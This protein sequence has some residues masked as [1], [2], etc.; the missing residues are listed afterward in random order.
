M[1]PEV[2]KPPLAPKPRLPDRPSAVAVQKVIPSQISKSGRGLYPSSISKGPKPPIAPKPNL[3]NNVPVSEVKLA[4][5]KNNLNW[6]SNGKLLVADQLVVL[7]VDDLSISDTLDQSESAANSPEIEFAPA[8]EGDE[9]N[10]LRDCETAKCRKNGTAMLDDSDQRVIAQ[11]D[12]G[13]VQLEDS[14]LSHLD[15]YGLC[16][17]ADGLDWQC[18]ASQAIV[19]VVDCDETDDGIRL[20]DVA[21][22]ECLLQ[23]APSSTLHAARNSNDEI[24]SEENVSFIQEKEGFHGKDLLEAAERYTSNT[25]NQQCEEPTK[26]LVVTT[27]EKADGIMDE[28]QLSRVLT[29][30][31]PCGL[32]DQADKLL[33]ETR[34]QPAPT[35]EAPDKPDLE[36]NEPVSASDEPGAGAG[37]PGSAA[38]E[39]GVE[40]DEPESTA[41]VLGA[42]AEES[43][44]ALDEPG[45]GADEP[46]AGADEPRDEDVEP[47][48]GADEPGAGADE[49]RDEDVEP[50]TGANEP[51]AGAD[52]PRDE[53]V[54]PRDEDVEPGA[55]ADEPGAGAD[56]PGTG[57]DEPGAGADE[58]G[59]GADEPRDEDVEP[60]TGADEPGAGADDPRDE[61]IEPGSGAD[62]PG[63]GAD[64]PGAEED[65]PGAGADEPG[66]G[67]EEPRD[68]DVEPGAGADVPGAGADGPGAE[69]DE[70]GAGADEPGAGA[71]E[72]R[73]EDVEPGTGADE[74]GTGAD[75]P[76]DEDDEPGTGADE[77]GTGADEPRDEDVKPGAGADGPGTGADEPRDEDV[78]PGAGAD[79]PGAGADEPGAG[80]DEPGDED[81]E[82]GDEDVEPGAGADGPGAR[83]DGPGARADGPGA[84]ADGPGA[85][86]DEPG[87]GADEPSASAD[88]PEPVA[89]ADEPGAGAD[90]PGAGADEPGAG[91]GA[92][93]PEAKVDKPRAGADELVEA[94]LTGSSKILMFEGDWGCSEQEMCAMALDTGVCEEKEQFDQS[95]EALELADF[96][97]T[98]EKDKFV[99]RE[100]CTGICAENIAVEDCPASSNCAVGIAA[101]AEYGSLLEKEAK[102]DGL[103]SVY[104]ASDD[105][106]RVNELIGKVEADKS[107]SADWRNTRTRTQ[108]LGAQVPET[109]P[110]EAAPGSLLQKPDRAA[111][112]DHNRVETEGE[113]SEN[114]RVFPAKHKHHT[115]YPRSYSVEGR[116]LPISVYGETEDSLLEDSR[117]KRKE[118]NLSL[119]SVVVSSGI[120]L[121]QN[122][123]PSSGASTP[124]SVVDIPPPFQLASITKKPITKSSPSLLVENES[125]DKY[126]K[127]NTK[128]KSSF[129][130]FLP[131]K[132]SLKKKIENKIAVEVNVNKTPSDTASAL[133]FDRRSLGSSPQIKTRS[134]KMRISD[135]SS[136]FLINKD[137]KRKG[138]PKP[139][140]RS[141]SRVESFEDR[142]RH[143]FTSLPLTKPRSIS[144]P[145]TDTSDY[146]NIPAVSS[147]YENVQIPPRRSGH[148]GT[149]TEFFEDPSRAFTSA[150]ENDGYV[151]MSSFTPFESRHNMEQ[152]LESV[153]S[154]TLTSC[155]PSG[156]EVVSSEELVN[157]SESEDIDRDLAAQND[158]EL[159]AYHIAKVMTTSERAY[160]NVLKVLHTNFRQAATWAVDDEACPVLDQEGVTRILCDVSELYELHQEI[161]RD[162]EQTIT[163]WEQTGPSL[164]H[165]ILAR[166]P[167]LTVYSRY[168]EL[169]ESNLAIL[170]QSCCTSPEFSTSLLEFEVYPGS[171]RLNVKQCLYMLLQRVPQYHLYLTDYLNNLCPNSAEYED[172]QAALLVVGDVCDQARQRV[173]Y[174]ENLQKLLEVEHRVRGLH[175]VVQP[176]RVLIKEGALLRV[177]EETLQHRYCF[178][179]NDMFLYTAPQHSGKYQLNK[180]L[181]LMGMKVNRVSVEETEKLFR[182]QSVQGSITLCASS[183]TERDEWLAAI[184]RAVED[185]Q[186]MQAFLAMRGSAELS[187]EKMDGGLG[188]KPPMLIPDSRVVMCMICAG[189]FSLTWRRRHCNACGKVVCRTCSK[190]KYPLKYLKGKL[191]RVCD[192]CHRELKRKELMTVNERSPSLPARS[193]GS[194]LSS[195]FHSFHTS[196]I[197]KQKRIPTALKEVAASAEGVSM[198]GYLQR[199]KRNKRHWK[200]L[201]FVIHEKVLYT[202]GAKGNK[203]A[204][205]SLPLLGF[206][207]R[208][209]KD[210]ELPGP[211]TQFQLYHKNI[212]YY[213]FK[214]E[215]A[216]TAQR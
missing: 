51:G 53:D 127:Q 169:Y 116:D 123:L 184:S 46:G 153:D 33:D 154:E 128:K 82:P 93:E 203:V 95:D 57:A 161:L 58:P 90:E 113:V 66:A 163:E 180:T 158:I 198:S 144:F 3:A 124:S 4:L 175:Q 155:S 83:A 210:D 17:D 107:V 104:F 81:V 183:S 178:L 1:E 43:G 138:T 182:I 186:R 173:T 5:H 9:T 142:S 55:G 170:D 85:G 164:A 165:V 150:S 88:V 126:L 115:F 197:R 38:D 143:S 188:A 130:R 196:S 176:G 69:E 60:G 185:Y 80:A 202:Y 189:D 149:F 179:M 52:E 31:E 133:D 19:V 10:T 73:D 79:G 28:T 214:S 47:G 103:P 14:G 136:T 98:V 26:S 54:E 44:S 8:V 76:R 22:D 112:E 49:P 40:A 24:C 72:P 42:R 181:P 34:P 63:A 94:K 89:G 134:G 23:K 209:S 106:R 105:L 74:P 15:T 25:N 87:A 131:I 35:P 99:R 32:G 200:K 187:P 70:P 211:S 30:E 56:E 194:A 201:W 212:L 117:M 159:E 27:S 11:E 216:H 7:N 2:K 18:F 67:A 108:S 119:P 195:V 16:S 147:D 59:A 100:A 208:G 174:G 77:P 114:A 151:D 141:V 145:N 92:D 206:T 50:G 120:L 207:I 160:V 12:D 192:Q 84:G 215:D 152:E 204:A 48:A 193:P 118:D 102:I 177:T 156:E 29:P 137:G 13:F 36:E 132:L 78:E 110:E 121:K 6:R 64:G 166:G 20:N 39:H 122:P 65:E 190:N 91:A 157:S 146:E 101:G 86:A 21:W 148:S 213:S 199:S 125:P 139:F 168:I 97:I 172:T 62:E 75:E 61:D 109:V 205:E 171:N 140:S 129:K 68:E 37:E 167:R 111:V 162:L 71:E 191:S 41:N 96:S 135:S 45:A